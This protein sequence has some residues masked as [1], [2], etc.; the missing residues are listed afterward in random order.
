MKHQRL[1]KQQGVALVV[2]LIF[3]LI[4]TIIGISSMQG[5]SIQEKMAGNLRDQHTALNDAETALRRGEAQAS[6]DFKGQ[7]LEKAISIS[8]TVAS[9]AGSSPP[10]WRAELLEE[11]SASTDVLA[12]PEFAV[13]RVTASSAGLSGQADVSLESIYT[14]KN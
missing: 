7:N 12:V 13:I 9:S 3:M 10:T 14:I 8:G 4:L 6:N 5:T 1:E 11:F 2:A